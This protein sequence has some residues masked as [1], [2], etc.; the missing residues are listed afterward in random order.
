M[1]SRSETTIDRDYTYSRRFL[2]TISCQQKKAYIDKSMIDEVI[3]YLKYFIDSLH[4]EHYVYE[5]SGKY[6]QL[7]WHA[8]VSVTKNFHFAHYTSFGAINITGQSYS[9]NWKPITHL[10]GAIRYINK[11]LKYSTQFQIFQDNWYSI[12]RFNE[13]YLE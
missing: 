7:H 12:N 8:V 9:I 6:R 4:V 11:D 1:Q 3:M 13:T 10:P 2:V 5:N